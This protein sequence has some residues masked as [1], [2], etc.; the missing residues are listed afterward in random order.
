M[1]QTN[2]NN[3]KPITVLDCVNEF[4]GYARKTVEG[5]LEMSRVVVEARSLKGKKDFGEFCDLI[6]FDKRSSTIKKLNCIGKKYEL[7]NGIKEYLPSNW[8]TLYQISRIDNDQIHDLIQSKVIH[9]NMTGKEVKNFHEGVDEEQKIE[10]EE[11]ESKEYWFR[12][13]VNPESEKELELVRSMI[14][15]L[16]EEGLVIEV[17]SSLK[18]EMV[19]VETV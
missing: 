8:T 16:M 13:K 9:P 2:V 19:V 11:V 5:T 17:S 4:R 10:K 6:G 14:E 12:C 15:K 1:E 7:L 18:E 3:T